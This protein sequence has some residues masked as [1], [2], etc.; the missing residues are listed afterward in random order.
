MKKRN[1]GRLLLL[2]RDGT[3]MR[4]VG[5]PRRPEDVRI[6]PGVP[7]A[8]NALKKAGFKIVIVSNQSGVGRGMITLAQV[9]QVNRRFVQLLRA[10]KAGVDGLYWCPHHPKS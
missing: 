4:E 9:K 3:L 8:L 5:F 6:L 10:K 7:Q 2:D 1:S